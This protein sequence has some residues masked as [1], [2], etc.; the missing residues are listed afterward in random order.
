[1]YRAIV[2]GEVHYFVYYCV[3]HAPRLNTGAG[4][5]RNMFLLSQ[6]DRCIFLTLG[7]P[8]G[9]MFVCP[10][11]YGAVCEGIGPQ[12]QQLGEERPC[13]G[14]LENVFFFLFLMLFM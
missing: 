2:L 13:F 7:V 6:I 11:L 10:G 12:P 3:P 8:F 9:F 5:N 4:Q 1:M 14:V